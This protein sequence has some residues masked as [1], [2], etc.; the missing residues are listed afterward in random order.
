MSDILRPDIC[1]I[2]AGS[3]G[4][5]VAAAGA[6]FG[7]SVVLVEK[8]KMGGDC[9]N[10][11][12][13][14]SK[15]LIA[16]A[17]HAHAIVEA[18]TFGVNA[19]EVKVD[20]KRVHDH[21]HEV[22]AAIHPNDSQERFTG[23]GVNVIRAPGRFA[24]R[25][26]LVAGDTQIKARR[27]VIATG[28][29]PLAPP[30]P[31][32]DTVPYFTNESI[33]DLTRLPRHLVIIGGGPIGMELAQAFV[34]LGAQVTVL[35]AFAAMGK[36][37]PELAGRVVDA[38]RADGAT[39]R[40]GAKVTTVAK[41]GRAGVRVS[42]ETDT[43]EERVEGSDLLVAVGRSLNVGDLGLEEAGVA[44]DRGG[45]KV[46]A[47]L[48]TTNR[49]IYAAG[50]IAGGY[51]FTHWA[52]Y[53]AGLVIRSI[54][55]RIGGKMNTDLITWA[56]YTDPELAHVGLSED[57]ARRRH[58]DILILRWPYAENDRAQ[59]ERATTGMVKVITTK[60]GRIV[61]AGVVGRNAGELIALWALAA[62]QK[63]NVKALTA[64]VLPY[65]T[66]SETAKRAAVTYYTPSLQSPWLKRLIR[67]LRLF[68]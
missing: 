18:R 2:G 31:G 43:G 63:L 21:I 68:R 11:G 60:K 56:T 51:Q 47:K 54:L 4:L 29:S 6:A 46:N 39:I 8:S 26:T 55:F 35:E 33:F 28:S 30:I 40:E 42:F 62:S 25:R 52:G 59:T 1:V 36:D 24:D 66:L 38:V 23:L 50:D 65:P 27:F 32:L 58:R 12:C 20:Y 34:R 16:A 15:A 17:K 22:I 3:A 49:R 5:T 57:Q 45:I 7:A 64:T 41:H 61:G 9:L 14:P 19:S 48:R 53:Q 13:V 67:F 44:C 10:Y 37:D